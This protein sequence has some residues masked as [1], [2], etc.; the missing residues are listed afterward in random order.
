MAPITSSWFPC[1][2]ISFKPCI[3]A[4]S[5]LE[6]QGFFSLLKTSLVRFCLFLSCST[7]IFIDQQALKLGLKDLN[8]YTDILSVHFFFFFVGRG[9]MKNLRSHNIFYNNWKISFNYFLLLEN[10]KLWWR[11][12]CVLHLK[13]D[14][15]LGS[16]L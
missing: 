14:W 7:E 12:A 4:V 3:S 11:W 10:Q 13:S 2:P 6:E 16:C 15:R 9:I 5:T 1:P 8:Q